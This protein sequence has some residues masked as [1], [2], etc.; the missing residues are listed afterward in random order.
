MSYYIGVFLS[1]TVFAAATVFALYLAS[2]PYKQKAFL[3]SLYV[4]IV[5][6]FLSEVI[7][8]FPVNLGISAN[9]V[10]SV[11][12]ALLG[13]IHTAI[14]LFIVD[15]DLGLVLDAA[16]GLTP[17]MTTVYTTW[18]SILLVLSPILTAGAALSFLA[19][20]S[21]HNKYFFRGFSKDVY[22]FSELNEYSVALATSIKTASG[23]LSSKRMIVFTDVYEKD[24]EDSSELHDKAKKLDAVIFK[25]D[26]T[27]VNFRKHSKK[28]KLYFFIMGSREEENLNQTVAL[29]AE[30]APKF[31]WF[32]R[33][34]FSDKTSGYDYKRGDTRIYLFTTSASSELQLRIMKPKYLKIRRVNERQSLIYKILNDQGMEIF[35]S[36]KETGNTVLNTATG[37]HDREKKISALIV[38]LGEYGTEMLRALS[39]FCQMHPYRAEFHAYDAD[40][41]AAGAFRSAYPDLF[42]FD[43]L[44]D[45][46][47]KEGDPLPHNGDFETPGEAHYKITIHSGA[48]IDTYDFDKEISSFTD[49]TY[50][51]VSLGDDDENIKTCIKIRTLLRRVGVEPVIHTIIYNPNK[52]KMLEKDYILGNDPEK[53]ASSL[54]ISSFGDLSSNYSED[55]VLNSNVEI[56]ALNR[57]MEYT[58]KVVAEQKLEGDEKEQAI[59]EGEESFWGSDYN[60][61]S[62]IASAIHTKFKR[63]C[64]ITA[65]EKK[66]S[67]RTFEE[68]MFYAELEHRRW[69]AYIRSEGYVK[70]EK[71]DKLIKTHHLLVPFDEL[72]YSEKIKDDD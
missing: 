17:T 16:V 7:L 23:K 58:Y 45:E 51:F 44:K 55:C 19:N 20:I 46:A 42:D 56:T 21:A 30:R 27:A 70:G 15:C 67:E 13:S 50:V 14:R 37:E 28:T 53:R 8:F 40:K 49:T 5:G 39:W 72:P 65:S 36:A 3:K 59:R 31:H 4:F 9:S 47:P 1:L 35:D 66:P 60:Y 57:H 12:L 52:K 71:R 34:D 24:E 61:R 38:G 33:K 25:S 63:E 22:I 2:K 43:P 6:V 54:R 64:K 32:R 41:N 26:I 68:K 29:S 48:Q 18:G 10:I 69:N 62:S 11:L